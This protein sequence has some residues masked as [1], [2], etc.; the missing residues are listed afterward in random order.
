[1]YKIT[2]QNR[3]N[4]SMIDGIIV[5]SIELSDEKSFIGSKKELFF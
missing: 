1:M 2:V 4:G 5:W 3:L